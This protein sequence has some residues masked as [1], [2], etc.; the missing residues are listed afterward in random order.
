VQATASPSQGV[1]PRVPVASQRGQHGHS[2]QACGRT[3]LP[4][5]TE[6]AWTAFLPD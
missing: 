3:A 2:E 5:E 1:G 6:L 4:G